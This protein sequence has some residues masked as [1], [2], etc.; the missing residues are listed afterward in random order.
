MTEF[1]VGNL[2]L[3]ITPEAPSGVDLE[4]D[5]AFAEMENAAKGKPEQQF[6]DTIVNAE[7]PDWREVRRKALDVLGRSKD[8]RAGLYLAKAG[9]VENGLLEFRDA[10]SLLYGYVERFWDSVHP[11]LDPDD[12]NDPTIRVNALMELCDVPTTIHFLRNVPLIR[13]IGIGSVTAKDVAIAAG[14]IEAPANAEPLGSE[15]INVAFRECEL[16][17]LQAVLKAATEARESV[18]AIERI[19]TDRVGPASAPNFEL[20]YKEL[21]S[22]EKILRGHY[23]ERAPSEDEAVEPPV[24]SEAGEA[25]ASPSGAAPAAQ[26][27]L[28]DI[29][30]RDQAIR[31]LDRIIEYFEKQEPSSPLPLLLRRAKRLSKKTFLEIL[32]DISP[33]GFDQALALGGLDEEEVDHDSA[34]TESAPKPASTSP[35]TADASTS[36]SSTAD[37]DY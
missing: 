11:Q 8:L 5:A 9:L 10:L 16:E 17:E 27:D 6:G 21:Q 12:D 26:V 14:E 25:P 29:G 32:R 37:D 2:L 15:A 1:D 18:S 35:S 19:V 13:V 4:Y 30:S 31:A 24:T 28:T 22:V 7:E 23:E 34:V 20:L 3:E 33:N 36:P